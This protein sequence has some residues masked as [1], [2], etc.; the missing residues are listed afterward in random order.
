MAA[1]SQEEDRNVP[2]EVRI[3]VLA[4]HIAAVAAAIAARPAHMQVGGA[5][6]ALVAAAHPHIAVAVDV[7]ERPVGS[8]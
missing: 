8:Q 6:M 4:A 5:C 3:V 1:L 2:A 7:P